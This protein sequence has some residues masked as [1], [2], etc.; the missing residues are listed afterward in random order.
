MMVSNG[1]HVLVAGQATT[2]LLFTAMADIGCLL[3]A[4]AVF[5]FEVRAKR[6][7]DLPCRRHR[8]SSCSRACHIKLGRTVESVLTRVV[9]GIEGILLD[10]APMLFY[11]L[12]DGGGGFTQ[13]FCDLTKRVGSVK[14]HFDLDPVLQGQVLVVA[15]GNLL[16]EG[17][18]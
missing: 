4:W 7:A 12:G 2:V 10:T 15:H 1:G 6:G 14:F 11:L 3:Q 17:P 5:F 18:P 9:A 13:V 16:R 8:F